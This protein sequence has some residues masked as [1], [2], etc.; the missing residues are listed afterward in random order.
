MRYTSPHLFLALFIASLCV[1]VGGQ[2]KATHHVST[3]KYVSDGEFDPIEEFFD[4]DDEEEEDTTRLVG[5]IPRRQ[6]KQEGGSE[7]AP[8]ELKKK[9]TKKKKGIN[10]PSGKGG[11]IVGSVTTATPKAVSVP[12]AP[13]P[14]QVKVRRRI[15]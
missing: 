2:E 6:L 7:K 14:K 10:A 1:V 15:V 3:E 12:V 11:I 4:L 5:D 8:R 9:R 13:T